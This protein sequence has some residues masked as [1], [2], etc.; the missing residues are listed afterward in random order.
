MGFKLIIKEVNTLFISKEGGI[1]A[2]EEGL[3]Q[4]FRNKHTLSIG[5]KE[6]IK[7][8]N[9]GTIT[10]RDLEI[11][12]FL[13]KFTFA[14]AEQVQMY[15][16]IKFPDFAANVDTIK[17]R[18]DKL[19]KY[20]V[21]NKFSFSERTDNALEIFCMD[22]G[23]RHL[24]A[25]YSNEDTTDW[26]T[27]ETM[28]GSI[29]IK[30]QLF[31]TEFYLRLMNTSGSKVSS[32][33][34]NPEMRIGRQSIIPSFEFS[35]DDGVKNSYLC[36]IVLKE[37]MPSNFKTQA[38]KLESLLSTNGWKKYYYEWEKPPALLFIADSDFIAL[39]SS[40]LFYRSTNID[41]FR[42]TTVDRIK[43]PLY[44]SGVF[45]K[46]IDRVEE[47]EAVTS[48]RFQNDE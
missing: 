33:T 48:S 35:L 37:D 22:L 4:H 40:R 30:R 25:S 24:L 18:M 9:L 5:Y 46:Y 16:E 29:V 2:I 34:P 39:D 6:I 47:L 26:Y 28:K 12:K 21:L 3:D 14:T 38:F 15:L 43:N 42:V 44:E 1:K 13:F 7:M 36:E 41:R 8:K 11:T 10:N 31:I 19:V 23:G 32:F 20:R 27:V 45:M 17:A